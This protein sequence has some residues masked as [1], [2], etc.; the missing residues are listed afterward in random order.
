MDGVDD[1]SDNG[2]EGDFEGQ[3]REKIMWFV[4]ENYWLNEERECL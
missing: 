4:P 1:K 2:R 3:R